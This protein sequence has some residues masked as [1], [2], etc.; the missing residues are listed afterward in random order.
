MVKAVSQVQKGVPVREVEEFIKAVFYEDDYI[1]ALT[2][3]SFLVYKG[4]TDPK[5]LIIT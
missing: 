4:I 1:L 3:T 5:V 2:P